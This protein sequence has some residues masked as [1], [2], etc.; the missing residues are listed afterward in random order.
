LTSYQTWSENFESLWLKN[1]ALCKLEVIDT[2]LKKLSK[3]FIKKESQKTLFSTF[4]ESLS[5]R[6][7]MTLEENPN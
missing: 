7:Y 3:K 4:K 1:L 2:L 6:K 5:K